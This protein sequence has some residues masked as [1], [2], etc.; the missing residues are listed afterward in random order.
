[1]PHTN[2]DPLHIE[3]AAVD[4]HRDFPRFEPSRRVSANPS[5]LVRHVYEYLQNNYLLG[6]FDRLRND[7]TEINGNLS[8]KIKQRN[9]AKENG[10]DMANLNATDDI[11]SNIEILC[12]DKVKFRVNITG[13]ERKCCGI[14]YH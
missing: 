3:I 9:Q 2:L 7:Q 11:F 4:A 5:L 6:Q 12:N 14:T 10:D 1:M 13:F 8:R